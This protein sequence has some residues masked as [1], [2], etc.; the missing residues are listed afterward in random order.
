MEMWFEIGL[1]G[2]RAFLTR[3]IP[4]AHMVGRSG[5]VDIVVF[6]ASAVL[7]GGLGGGASSG[8]SASPGVSGTRRLMVWMH[9]VL[10]TGD[11]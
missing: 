10:E 5:R 9:V 4:V 1:G 8:V 3:R 6:K 11:W 7:G 2:T